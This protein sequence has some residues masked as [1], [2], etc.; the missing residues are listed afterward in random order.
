[1]QFY[2]EGGIEV[3]R[4]EE[5]GQQTEPVAMESPEVLE[6]AQKMQV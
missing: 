2:D 6:E 4:G 5:V 3:A 1:M